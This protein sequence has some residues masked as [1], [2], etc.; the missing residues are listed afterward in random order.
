MVIKI[1]EEGAY[2]PRILD[3]SKY[4]YC[5]SSSVKVSN[6]FHNFN[7]MYGQVYKAGSGSVGSRSFSISG[8]FEA[9]FPQDVERFR[10]EVFKELFD[11]P[12]M[13]FLEE[14]DDTYYNCVLD[15][16]VSTT[17][18]AGWEISRV[19]S[20]SFNL[21]AY[22]PFRFG[23]EK[24][25]AISKTDDTFSLYYEGDV[26]CFPKIYIRFKGK[27]KIV[28]Q[29]LLQNEDTQIKFNKEIVSLD[30]WA[31]FCIQ[32]GLI[33]PLKKTQISTFVLDSHSVLNPFRL[34]SGENEIFFNDDCFE[35]GY[36]VFMTAQ[37]IYF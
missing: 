7:G 14:K 16:N 10:G 35:G 22:E 2:E 37:N 28:E 23:E 8:N 34:F 18:N 32:N 26:P 30:E 9:S 15:G 24:N 36:R 31:Y 29:P 19:F 17:Y 4:L 5:T 1:K 25:L 33:R 13:L 11:K 20:L 27:I 21:L 3:F 6:A 12:L